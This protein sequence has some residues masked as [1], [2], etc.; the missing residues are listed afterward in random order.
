MS[1]IVIIIVIISLLVNLIIFVEENVVF[2]C[3]NFWVYIVEFWLLLIMIIF[4]VDWCL[5]FMGM[6]GEWKGRK[7]GEW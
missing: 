7:V 5:V 4:W 6:G 1:Y 2:E 3:E